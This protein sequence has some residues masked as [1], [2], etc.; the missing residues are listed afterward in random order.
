ME[1]INHGPLHSNLGTGH[2]VGQWA[3]SRVL[4]HTCD[5]TL[6]DVR[7]YEQGMDWGFTFMHSKIPAKL[8]SPR[9]IQWSNSRESRRIHMNSPTCLL[10][11]SLENS[12]SYNCPLSWRRWQ[13]PI[14][15]ACWVWST[16]CTWLRWTEWPKSHSTPYMC[17]K[18]DTKR[19]E[20]T[21]SNAEGNQCLQYKRKV[22]ARRSLTLLVPSLA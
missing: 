10:M 3:R 18:P 1:V 5:R 16:G 22:Q 13:A 11:A 17:H 14:L 7:S 21:Q 15:D 19:S 4:I 12:S 8:F 2:A 6:A 20:H 9:C